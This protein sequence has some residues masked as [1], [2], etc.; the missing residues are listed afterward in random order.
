MSVIDQAYDIFHSTVSAT[1]ATHGSVLVPA[2]DFKELD[3][4]LIIEN[5]DNK[6]LRNGFSIRFEGDQNDGVDLTSITRITQ[7]VYVTFTTANFGTHKDTDKR[8]DAEKK[9]LAMK[10]A[11]VL[12]M[13]LNPQ[14]DDTVAR[15]IYQG[16]DPIELILD[17]DERN[18]LMIRSTY[19]I[20][21]FVQSTI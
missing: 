11:V 8:K 7:T 14:L 21:Y 13:A 4:N 18:Y 3:D 10:D 16:S 19:T 6:K 17:E 15:C 5:N 2:V 1:L 12:A 9:L 20:G